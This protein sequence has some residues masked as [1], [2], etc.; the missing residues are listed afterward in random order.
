MEVIAIVIALACI[1]QSAFA[2]DEATPSPTPVF[3]NHLAGPGSLRRMEQASRQ[4][5]LA[6]DSQSQAQI[7]QQK[8][9]E[10]RSTA[11]VKAQERQAA[12]AREKA[13]REVAAQNRAETRAANPRPTSDL[14]SRMGFSEQEIAAQ[15]AREQSGKSGV[16]EA[17]LSTPAP[18]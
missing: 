17:P 13:H 4:R 7:R 9:A 11:A 8:N 3:R 6:T 1:S 15:K 10:R 2:E 16:K 18:R 14:M 5:A 12:R